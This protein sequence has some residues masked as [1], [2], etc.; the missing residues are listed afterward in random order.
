MKRTS[1]PGTFS[2]EPQE[3]ENLESA[4]EPPTACYSSRLVGATSF[5]WPVVA[6]VPATDCF[7]P[8]PAVSFS[9]SIVLA[10]CDDQLR[11]LQ[12]WKYCVPFVGRY[13]TSSFAVANR[14]MD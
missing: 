8:T 12:F 6:Q 4:P 11:M 1:L 9:Q 3:F 7:Y 13:E 10:S 2:T 14:G 5:L